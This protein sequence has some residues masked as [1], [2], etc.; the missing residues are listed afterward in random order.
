[1]KSD[2]IGVYDHEQAFSFLYL[3]IIGA[4]PRP[5]LAASQGKD[6]RFLEQHIFYPSLRGSRLNLSPFE[7]KLGLLADE[8]LGTYVESVPT[9]WSEGRELMGTIA[10]YL[11]EARKERETLI[12]FVKHLL[13]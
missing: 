2:H 3:P 13:R 8:Q 4:A 10:T 6:F 12:N 7:E 9:E 1:M 11:Q 5:W